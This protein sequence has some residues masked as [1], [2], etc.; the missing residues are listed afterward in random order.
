MGNAHYVEYGYHGYRPR[1]KVYIKAEPSLLYCSGLSGFPA[2]K[3]GILA[4][5]ADDFVFLGSDN[6]L[7]T[8]G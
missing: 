4:A 2:A 7:Y 3:D 8:A 1:V 5:V 6:L